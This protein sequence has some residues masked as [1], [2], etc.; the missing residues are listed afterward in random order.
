MLRTTT[1]TGEVG[2]EEVGGDVSGQGLGGEGEE[3]GDEIW[4]FLESIL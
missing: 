3:G 1:I 2:G 4:H